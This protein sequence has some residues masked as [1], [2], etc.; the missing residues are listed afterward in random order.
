M[1]IWTTERIWFR[2]ET[3]RG[4]LE[5][6]VVTFCILI[7]VSMRI[8]VFWDLTPP[9]SPVLKTEAADTIYQTKQCHIP[10]DRNLNCK[11]LIWLDT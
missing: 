8:M 5:E 9:D 11:K 6:A 7:A 3:I 4:L 1:R 10:E 2:I